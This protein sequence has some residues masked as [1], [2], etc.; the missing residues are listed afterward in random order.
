[1]GGVSEE[2]IVD[3]IEG[4][5]AH[6]TFV[7]VDLEG[8]A[9]LMVSYATSMADFVVIPPRALHGVEAARRGLP[10]FTWGQHEDGPKG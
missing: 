9:S 1:V 6:S 8:M 5:A 2:T 7:I 4:A 10:D 3:E